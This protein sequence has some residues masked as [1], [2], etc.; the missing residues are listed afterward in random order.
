MPNCYCDWVEVH[1]CGLC[2]L[3]LFPLSQCTTPHSVLE[4]TCV[5]LQV[6]LMQ[7]QVV[8]KMLCGVCCYCGK[9]TNKYNRENLVKL[10]SEIYMIQVYFYLTLN[11]TF[12]WV[13]QL[14]G[15][16]H[17]VNNS[18]CVCARVCLMMT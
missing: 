7:K 16:C 2:L 9:S 11:H 10:L 12:L 8:S 6:K 14:R 18:V 4:I 3:G 17:T 1:S 15:C 5:C 13:V